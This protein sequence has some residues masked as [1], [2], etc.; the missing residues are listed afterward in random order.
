VLQKATGGQVLASSFNIAAFNLG[1]A[2][3]AWLGGMVIS[4]GPGLGAVSW[5]AALLTVLGFVVAL[6][7]VRLDIRPSRRVAIVTCTETPL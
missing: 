2:I 5:V 4:H 7:S 1:N 3:G 6:W